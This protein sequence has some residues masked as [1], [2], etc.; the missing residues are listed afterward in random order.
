MSSQHFT[1]YGKEIVISE[2]YDSY[3]TLRSIFEHEAT[4]AVSKF[5]RKYDGYGSIDTFIEHGFDD[6]LEIIVE[7]IDRMA[8]KEILI[9]HARIYDCDVDRFFREYYAGDNG[10]FVWDE[11]YSA[12][13]DK[14][15]AIRLNQQQLDEY[16]R[17]RRENRSR[18]IGGGFGLGGAI[19]GAMKAGAMNMLSGAAHGLFN[20][21]AKIFS[22][23]SEANQKSTLYRSKATR[24]TIYDGIYDS[25]F[26]IHRPLTYLLSIQNK[27]GSGHIEYFINGGFERAQAVINNFPSMNKRDILEALPGIVLLSPYGSDLYKKLLAIFGDRDGELEKIAEYFGISSFHNMKEKAVEN[28]FLAVKESLS[29]S[30]KLALEARKSFDEESENYGFTQARKNGLAQIDAVLADYDLKART[31]DEFV[32][33]TREEADRARQQLSDIK[34]LLS[35]L[36]YEHSED[37]ALTAKSKLK[38]YGVQSAI[39]SKYFDIINSLIDKFDK[40]ARTVNVTIKVHDKNEVLFATREEAKKARKNIDYVADT[41]TSLDNKNSNASYEET[42]KYIQEVLTNFEGYDAVPVVF[43]SII[44]PVMEDMKQYLIV[45]DKEMRTVNLDDKKVVLDTREEATKIREEFS[46]LKN[47][48]ASYDYEHSAEAAVNLLEKLN[49][50]DWSNL[51]LQYIEIHNIKRKVQKQVEAFDKEARTVE[52]TTFDTVEEAEV[53]RKEL[54]DIQKISSPMKN[55]LNTTMK[56][57]EKQLQE[58]SAQTD[59]A[60]SKVASILSEIDEKLRTVICHGT[61]IVFDSRYEVS[62]AKKDIE[63][64]DKY[65]T[66]WENKIFSGVP[67]EKLLTLLNNPEFSPKVRELYKKLLDVQLETKKTKVDEVSLTSLIA[68]A[69]GTG[70]IFYM[71]TT[72]TLGAIMLLCSIYLFWRFTQKIYSTYKQQKDFK[73]LSQFM[74]KIKD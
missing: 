16:R 30:E 72:T 40:E 62:N 6:G 8:I 50:Y 15:L 68:F 41:L 64:I 23:I 24:N 59:I 31:V 48:L 46:Y 1:L 20:T 73:L 53:V 17:R 49:N 13:E 5:M 10:W 26:Y 25:V 54:D 2:A 34:Q 36:D 71:N 7:V 18:W 29:T 3:N 43:Q 56:I 14:Y 67:D 22:A 12:I 55:G 45:I 70:I 69:V 38:S 39:L 63:E 37:D 11:K 51:I 74:S 58:Y 28:L 32:M 47:L 61:S 27:L 33:S 44:I 4:N 35:G 21:G 65:Y 57:V 52:N 19:K 60:R 42:E 66:E 9:N